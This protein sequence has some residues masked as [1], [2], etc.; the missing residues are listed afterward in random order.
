MYKK[1]IPQKNHYAIPVSTQE[2]AHLI[3][4]FIEGYE[5]LSQAKP[6][7]S[8]FGASKCHPNHKYYKLAHK[9]GLQLS[10]AGFSVVTG[11]GSGIMAAAN[12]GAYHGNSL[13]VGLTVASPK[14]TPHTKHHDITLNFSHTFTRKVMLIKDATSCVVLPGGFGT[15]D[16]LAEILA[17]AQVDK[18]K[19]IP[20][21][22]VNKAFW[23]PLILWFQNNLLAEN[24]ITKKDLNLFSIVETPEEVTKRIVEYYK[25]HKELDH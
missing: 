12:K 6:Y 3:T 18:S 19:K 21:L 1:N 16:E 23:T 14:E 10:N 15:L 5:E 24:M 4:E 25:K 17:L 22:L 11:G 7:V 13:S 8:I 9:I 20:I 2:I